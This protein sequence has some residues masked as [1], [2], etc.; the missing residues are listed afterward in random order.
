MKRLIWLAIL[1]PMFAFANENDRARLQDYL[2]VNCPAFDQNCNVSS[3][4][5][6]QDV[7]LN[8]L[9]ENCE[10]GVFTVGDW[11]MDMDGNVTNWKFL[12]YYHGNVGYAA[13][14]S[15][16]AAYIFDFDVGGKTSKEQITD[17]P[18]YGTS[19]PAM[20]G[21]CKIGQYIENPVDF[22]TFGYPDADAQF[23]IWLENYEARAWRHEATA[24]GAV[25]PVGPQGATGSTGAT[26]SDG[27]TGATGLPGIPGLPG[28]T[29]VPGLNGADG[30]DGADGATGVDGAV[31]P[32]GP[33]GSAGVVKGL[34]IYDANGT[35][36]STKTIETI[37]SPQTP[38][39]QVYFYAPMTG[40]DLL[41]LKVQTNGSLSFSGGP[42]QTLYFSGPDCT[43]TSYTSNARA[44]GPAWVKGNFA[45]APNGDLH[46]QTGSISQQDIQYQSYSNGITRECSNYSSS[47]Q[48]WRSKVIGS[49]TTPY[50]PPFTVR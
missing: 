44:T 5:L 16:G 48:L 3:E 43:G 31:G 28:A 26:G 27:A 41:L 38:L 2:D 6:D 4:I 30:V 23:D 15:T 13:E 50:V 45:M 20:S 46:I 11:L 10:A 1:L 7:R 12:R 14:H 9:E 29:G 35:K 33:A 39:P 21:T 40:G 19:L 36:V 47:R 42:L 34:A 49:F 17:Y 18:E 22:A 37:A 8:V 32:Q 25:G 24:D